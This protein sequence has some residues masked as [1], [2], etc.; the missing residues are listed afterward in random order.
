MMSPNRSV[1]G[2]LFVWL[3]V[4]L[5]PFLHSLVASSLQVAFSVP[6][7][8]LGEGEAVE[9]EEEVNSNDTVASVLIHPMQLRLSSCGAQDSDAVEA[10]AGVDSG[11][12][13]KRESLIPQFQWLGSLI[14]FLWSHHAL[15]ILLGLFLKQ[16][17]LRLILLF[18]FIILVLHGHSSSFCCF[19]VCCFFDFQSNS[20]TETDDRH[21]NIWW[22]LYHLSPPRNSSRPRDWPGF[23]LCEHFSN[24]MYPWPWRSRRQGDRFESRVHSLEQQENQVGHDRVIGRQKEKTQ[25]SDRDDDARDKTDG[26]GG[27]GSE[28]KANLITTSK[29]T[30]RGAREERRRTGYGIG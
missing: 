16:L 4:D 17:L 15:T 2:C 11:H 6:I 21:I 5:L 22:H 26:R 24:R 18:R 7:N 8:L 10:E 14:L 13:S 28:H 19:R 23:V 29:A 27:G 9:E 25:A 12:N 3:S 1:C 20:S 30:W